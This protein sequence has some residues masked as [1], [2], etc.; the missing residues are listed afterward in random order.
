ML[1][2]EL[3][4]TSLGAGFNGLHIT[5]GNSTVRGLMIDNFART[6]GPSF[7]GGNAIVLDTNGG[8]VIIGNI[9]GT[10][11]SGGAGTFSNGNSDV[12]VNAGSANNVIG[13][14]T[15]DTRNVL[16]GAGTGV[17]I[18]LNSGG[19]N[20]FE[21]NYVGTDA[22]GTSAVPNLDGLDESGTGD[23]IGGT[24]DPALANVFSGNDRSGVLLGLAVNDVLEGNLIGI[25]AQRT[26]TLTNGSFGI[27]AAGGSGNV[28]GG[29]APGAVTS[30]A[31]SPAT[32][33]KST[34]PAPPRARTTS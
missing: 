9:L 11:G 24:D 14:T 13:G 29:T 5:A 16:S 4:G 34:T 28:I 2:I 17:D 15:P 18:T 6:A 32:A 12:T 10:H 7:A 19:G 30:S 26:A 22:T 33:W 3:D 27:L 31:A 21:G 8:N 23:T 20:L 1:Q 25:N